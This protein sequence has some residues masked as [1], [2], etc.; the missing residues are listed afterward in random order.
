MT[1]ALSDFDGLLD[2]NTL[3]DW[4]LSRDLPGSGPILKV[5]EL[6]G[7]SQNH[8]FHLFRKDGEFV[9][10]RPP[11]HLRKNSNNTMLREAR[12]LKAL[13]GSAVPHPE[14]YDVCE[15]ADIIGANF[16]LMQPLSGFA[17]RGPLPGEYANNADWRAAMGPE[18]I[19]AAAAMNAID[20]RAVG[21]EDYGKADN[22]LAR[23]VP[24]WLGQLEGYAELKGYGGPQ[25][26]HV[27]AIA[28]WLEDKRPAQCRIGVIHGDF[29][30][31]NLMFRLDKPEVA[32]IIDWELS[33]LGDPM[34]DLAWVLT[35]WSEEGDPQGSPPMVEP[36]SGFVSRQ[37]LIDFYGELTGRDM[38]VVPWYFVLA[39]FKLGCVLEGTYAR[40]CAGLAPMEYGKPIHNYACWLFNKAAQLIR[41][42]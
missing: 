17:P 34:L 27:D 38:S 40:A 20:Y 3:H 12:L 13:A 14:F 2:W 30:F 7:G 19:R 33:T 31:P 36:W 25:L 16:Y 8:V 6:P 29:Q 22:W 23:Q 15:D 18:I 32:G 37:E 24:R 1:N 11:R 5:E 9:L 35:S 26:P 10:R 4:L 41:Q 39:C 42:Y 28:Q 21:L